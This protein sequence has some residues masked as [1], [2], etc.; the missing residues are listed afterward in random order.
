ML[1][2]GGIDA[3]HIAVQLSVGVTPVDAVP[4]QPYSECYPVSL[5][6]SPVGWIEKDQAPGLVETLRHF[7]VSFVCS[8]MCISTVLESL[9][10]VGHLIAF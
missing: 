1:G 10:A 5:D 9:K 4:S 8:A 7:K 2:V 3:S 6:G